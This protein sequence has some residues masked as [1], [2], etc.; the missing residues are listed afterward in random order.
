MGVTPALPP[1][2]HLSQPVVQCLA[3]ASVRYDVPE[4]LLHAIV[5]KENGRDGQCR[6]NTNGTLDCGLAQINS[7]WLTPFAKYGIELTHLRDNSCLNVNAA[8]YVLKTYHLI[9]KDWFE[10]TVSYNVGPN[11]KNADRRQ[12]GLRYATDVFSRWGQLWNKYLSIQ[13]PKAPLLY[14]A[15]TPTFNSQGDIQ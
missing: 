11:T 13:K 8:A 6:R 15:S 9:K 14:E 5:L 2:A 7:T 12:I 4:L 10:A 3:E 1:Y